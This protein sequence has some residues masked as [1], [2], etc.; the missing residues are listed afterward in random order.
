MSSDVQGDF[1]AAEELVDT[2]VAPAAAVGGGVAIVR[3]SG[4]DALSIVRRLFAPKTGVALQPRQ[5]TYGTLADAA[6]QPLDDCMVVVMPRPHSFTGEDV[7]EIHC[8]G[9]HSVVSA[10]IEACTSTGS[11]LAEP[12]EF[13]RRAFL[14]GRM[15]LSQAEALSDLIAAQTELSRRVALQQ[16]RGG[17]SGKV[18]GVRDSLID[19]AA[20]I[21]AHLDFPEED[22]PALAQDLIRHVMQT[23]RED[24][25]QLLAGYQRGRI[26]RDGARVV[27]AGLPNAGKSSLFNAIVGR[28]RA[29][30][31]PH[32][33]TTRD[34]IEATIDVR[35]VPV[36]LIDTA[37][38][39]DA[40]DEIEQIGIART[41]EEMRG[42][43]LVLMVFDVSGETD[44]TF[45]AP[46]LLEANVPVLFAFNK[47]DATQHRWHDDER[48][49]YPVSATTREGIDALLDAIAEKLIGRENGAAATITRARHAECL[50][51][52]D[53][54]L[55][56]AAAAFA[57]GESG[58]LVMVDLRDA[59]IHLG[60]I[61]G[62]R[63]DEQIL[64]RIFST[65]CL[66][67]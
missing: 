17:L 30:V 41:A 2:I 34:T 47:T 1:M 66:G 6:G 43:D 42:A 32:P 67:K 56:R 50:R 54:S 22:I 9:G 7:A 21:E 64:D 33:G 18:R 40:A 19:A 55:A 11:R 53:A 52:S 46:H 14:N 61:L 31:S 44:N 8:H 63:L 62:E 37:G 39:R 51:D 38:L 28:E 23:A 58:D 65:F 27:L 4:P 20:E 57:A 59:I 25:A 49:G 26:A 45:I 15:D 24:I 3:L 16:L 5:L 48:D 35:G 29:I 60:E 13:S 10:V 12:G 36:T